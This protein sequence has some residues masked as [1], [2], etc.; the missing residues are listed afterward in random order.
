M[1][2]PFTLP[3]WMLSDDGDNVT[4][5]VGALH[6]FN[7]VASA[8]EIQS[9]EISD[10]P[11]DLTIFPNGTVDLIGDWSDAGIVRVDGLHLIWNGDKPP[12]S[13]K[14]VRL[15]GK[16]WYEPVFSD[17]PNFVGRVSSIDWYQS[18][19]DSPR[20][21]LSTNDASIHSGRSWAYCLMLEL[22]VL[23]NSET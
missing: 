17:L 13:T 6:T 15:Q 23:T 8:C 5:V 14:R 10:D 18:E 21:V 19:Q 2:V 4:I 3:L 12:W 11:V 20:S 16:L 9:L 1:K 22:G 7:A